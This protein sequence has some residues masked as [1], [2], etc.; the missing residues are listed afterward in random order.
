MKQF[1]MLTSAAVFGLALTLAAQNAPA[2]AAS[3]P[4]PARH[5]WGDKDGDGKC[6]I[7]GLAVG[8]G[9]RATAG[10]RANGPGWRGARCNRPC[11]KAISPA[12][13]AAARQ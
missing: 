12:P 11:R 7:T 6:D 2:P 5:A 9:R 10:R 4:A 8:Q 3:S 13:P 1:L